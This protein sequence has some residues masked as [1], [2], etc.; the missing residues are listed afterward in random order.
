MNNLSV[1]DYYE[2]MEVNSKAN[3][4]IIERVFRKVGSKEKKAA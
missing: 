4:E 2:L 3:A 1:M